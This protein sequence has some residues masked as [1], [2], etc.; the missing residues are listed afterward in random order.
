MLGL[1]SRSGVQWLDPL[2]GEPVAVVDGLFDAIGRG[3][4]VF[5]RRPG[6]LVVVRQDGGFEVFEVADQQF[7]DWVTP[8]PTIDLTP[9]PVALIPTVAGDGESVDRDLILARVAIDGSQ[10]SDIPLPG[11]GFGYPIAAQSSDRVFAMWCGG[12]HDLRVFVDE[13]G[14]VTEQRFTDL[15]YGGASPSILDRGDKPILIDAAGQI[16]TLVLSSQPSLDVT[17]DLDLDEGESHHGIAAISEDFRIA[18]VGVTRPDELP[19]FGGRVTAGRLVGFDLV[20]GRIIWDESSPTP[21]ESLL[22]APDGLVY[23]YRS[24]PDTSGGNLFAIDPATGEITVRARGL[25]SE[26]GRLF[27]TSPTNAVTSA[28]RTSATEAKDEGPLFGVGIYTNT[29]LLF[30]DGLDGILAVEPDERLAARSTLEGQRAGDEPYSMIRV[31]DS[32]VVGSSEIFAVDIATREPTSLGLAT[33]FVPAA[34]P[35]RV[36]MIDWPGGSIGVGTPTVWQ[37]GTNGEQLTDPVTLDIDGF[38]A[39][40]GIPGGLAV[41]TDNGIQ[42]W[43][44]ASQT[45][46]SLPGDSENSQVLD[47]SDNDLVWCRSDCSELVVTDLST[48]TTEGFVIPPG[49]AFV[50]N[51][52]YASGQHLSPDGRFVAVLARRTDGDDT[53]LWLLD[54]ANE[55][56]TTVSDEDTHVDFLTWGTDWTQIFATSYSYGLSETTVWRYDLQTG[57]FASVTLPFGGALTPVAVDDALADAYITDLPGV[58]K[59]CDAR[60]VGGT[61]ADD[62][63]FR[64]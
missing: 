11:C 48:M 1:Q 38:P 53:S 51:S 26:P 31:G 25:S 37:V 55:N 8:N 46:R 2:S 33:I 9:R 27:V 63:W 56:I 7:V 44:A 23:G 4:A 32:L 52:S 54:R 30:D 24:D 3:D 29:L 20:R 47:A 42:L 21:I 61:L 43:A 45:A 49:F 15:I 58:E 16:W 5:G 57:H 12:S 28:D 13:A 6:E 36:W 62:C 18:I 60:T 17:G 34:E 22:A 50:T 41:E 39:A 19:G 14:D 10:W 40:Y 64:F 59:G 35:D